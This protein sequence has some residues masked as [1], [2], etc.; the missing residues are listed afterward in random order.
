MSLEY[1]IL[2][3]LNYGA[4][5]GYDL[6]KAFD[7]SIAHFWSANQSHIYRTLAR[8]AEDELVVVEVVEQDEH[9][10]RKIY[11]ITE[12]GRDALHT[13]LMTPLPF[14]PT[15]SP[16][17]IQTFFSGMLSNQEILSVLQYRAQT[18]SV[19]L[20]AFSQLPAQSQAYIQL[21][22][23]PRDVFFWTMTLEYGIMLAQ[24][25]LQWTEMVIE[26]IRHQEEHGEE[27]S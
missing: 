5:S 17:L 20:Q 1:A 21:I 11:H 8:L 9:P 13:W 27:F 7:A 25:K 3:F 14:E 10:D 22:Q 23:S 6:K 19:L 26:R 24:T 16:A 4:F 12:S 15:R 2:G 18:L